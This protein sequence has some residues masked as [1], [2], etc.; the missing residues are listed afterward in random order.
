MSERTP[1]DTGVRAQPHPWVKYLSKIGEWVAGS[2]NLRPAQDDDFGRVDFDD[3]SGATLATVY[4]DR[5]ETGTYTAHVFNFGADETIDIVLGEKPPAAERPLTLVVSRA[6]EMEEIRGLIWGTGLFQ[7]PWW[8]EVRVL[9]DGSPLT[10]PWETLEAGDVIQIE[11]D[12]EDGDEG[13]LDGLTTLTAPDIVA[14]ADKGIL[15]GSFADEAARDMTEDLGLADAEAADVVMQ[16]A[17][18]G[19]VI[20][21]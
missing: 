2:E 12:R 8:G 20:F 9:R 1:Y 17:V 16:I 3:D 19:K 14:A 10:T 7:Y 13:A 18:F 21:G 4:V 15:E 6:V 11:H 5:D